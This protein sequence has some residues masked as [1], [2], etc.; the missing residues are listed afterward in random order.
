[1]HLSEIIPEPAQRFQVDDDYTYGRDARYLFDQQVIAT[2]VALVAFGL[3]IA[4]LIG[5]ALEGQ[6]RYS[7]SH[8]YY[9]PIYGDL[10]VGSLAFIGAMLITF[11]GGNRAEN[12]VTTL[13]GIATLLV[14]L[15]P[16]GG[17]PGGPGSI[18]GRV[19]VR[20]TLSS[21]DGDGE[22]ATVAERAVTSSFFD[23]FHWAGAV[24]GFAA[25][26]TFG[27]LAFLCLVVFTRIDARANA[28]PEG[29]IKRVKIFRDRIYYLC[30]AVIL[31]CLLALG[32][33]A[34]W[35]MKAPWWDASRLTFIFETLMIWA[36]GASWLVKGRVFGRYLLD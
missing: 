1:M 28:T 17:A 25:A 33:H 2:L 5:W 23:L 4:C 16:T 35:L 7:V 34:F 31:I 32:A 6:L 19:L 12:R 27:V 11:R 24:H 20:L 22:T 8:Y 13:A 29:Q 14:P 10:F 36:F 21:K 15:F 3:P 30:G 9:A 18:P 26:C